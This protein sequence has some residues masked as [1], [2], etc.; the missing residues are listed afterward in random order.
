MIKRNAGFGR[1]VLMAGSALG[2]ALAAA[3]PAMAAP[4]VIDISGTVVSGFDGSG[5]FGAAG[6][7]LGGLS[8]TAHYV[9]DPTLGLRT[10]G[11]NYDSVFGGPHAWSPDP[12]R[13]YA[14]PSLATTLTINGHT[15]SIAGNWAA[16]FYSGKDAYWA[17][18]GGSVNGTES[19]LAEA[20]YGAAF[21]ISLSTA[22][23]ASNF[24]YSA[25]AFLVGSAYG[26]LNPQTITVGAAG[27]VSSVPEPVTWAMMLLGVGLIGG[28][29]RYRR[30][31]SSVSYV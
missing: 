18:V 5:L 24:T 27:G 14:D 19:A 25:G 1:K 6:G 16:D 8:Y 9:F 4:M 12:F 10:T 21:P 17:S 13:P 11:D 30:G 26:A 7:E 20:M 3:T 15:V 2:L 28:A 22:F 31:K 23:S 29:L